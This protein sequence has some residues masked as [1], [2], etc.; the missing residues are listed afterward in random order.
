MK[1]KSRTS[2]LLVVGVV[3]LL[4]PFAIHMLAH[5]STSSPWPEPVEGQDQAPNKRD[6]TLTAR[7][8]RFSPARIEVAQDDL[9]KL[10][11]TSEDNAYSLTIDEYRVSRRVPAGGST[12]LEF[13]AD[14]AGTFAF[15]SNLTNDARHAQMR[16]ELIVRSK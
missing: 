11:V 9:V 13:R 12:T 3:G 4:S 16:G 8:Y 7:N 6:I 10:T 14:R 15:Y 2:S 5:G 1:L